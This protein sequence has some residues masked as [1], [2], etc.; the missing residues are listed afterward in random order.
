MFTKIINYGGS[1]TFLTM[2]EISSAVVFTGFLNYG[3]SGA[4][5]TMLKISSA[6]VL[7]NRLHSDF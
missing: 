6:L 5:L 7:L 1:S 2:L 3:G 4:I